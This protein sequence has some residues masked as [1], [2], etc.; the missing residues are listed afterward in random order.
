MKDK[1][2]VKAGADKEALNKAILDFVDEVIGEE[3]PIA[4]DVHHHHHYHGGHTAM[5]K[6]E[7]HGAIDAAH[8]KEEIV[9][10]KEA[11]AEGE[12]DSSKQED[13]KKEDHQDSK[14]LY[15]KEGD[16]GE[17]AE[18]NLGHHKEMYKMGYKHGME[19]AKAHNPSPTSTPAEDAI[20]HQGKKMS[21]KS[22]EANVSSEQEDVLLK[23]ISALTEQVQTLQSAVDKLSKSPAT[24]RKSVRGVDFIKKSNTDGGDIDIDAPKVTNTFDLAKSQSRVAEIML[25]DGVKKGRL[26]ARQVAEYEST[27]NLMIPGDKQLVK[28]LVQERIQD[29][30]F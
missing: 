10:E 25:E 1:N 26:T 17:H 7:N 13:T 11:A 6:D 9:E 16:V 21:K 23:S 27:G 12:L 19:A 5:E 15:A 3:E 8:E 24:I 28:A 4:K 18:P 29:G 14:A 22:I 2:S 30:T 20:I